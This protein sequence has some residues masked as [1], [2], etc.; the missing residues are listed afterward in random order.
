MVARSFDFNESATQLL[1]EQI[2]I[3]LSKNNVLCFQESDS[4][5][6]DDILKR[7]V[8]SV[9]RI[10]HSGT[11]YL[12]YALLDIIVD[13]YFLVLEILGEQIEDLED[14][15]IQTASTELLQ[16]IY[17]LKRSVLLMRRHIWPFRE[18]VFRFNR[19]EV[20]LIE[21]STQL[22]LRD[23][24]DHVLRVTDYL[25]T[26]RDSLTGALDIYLSSVSNRMNEVMKVLTVISTVFIPLTLIAS[27]YGMNFVYMPELSFELGYPII[28]ISMLV[29]TLVLIYF[30]R[31][32]RWI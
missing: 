31:R 19:D 13:R 2:S 10:R 23:L 8:K 25:E 30:F 28:L 1:S 4:P 20:Y 29:I 6:F 7:A 22:Y 24:Y 3:I 17:R 16:D 18:V 11:D 15:L 9:G 32:I 26:Y 21:E 14:T 27:I 12:T 5:I